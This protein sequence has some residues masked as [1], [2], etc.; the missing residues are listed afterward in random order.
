MPLVTTYAATRDGAQPAGGTSRACSIIEYYI[1]HDAEHA[2]KRRQQTFTPDAGGRN[3]TSPT[4]FLRRRD[5]MRWYY[6]HISASPSP[7]RLHAQQ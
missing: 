5:T 1:S 7:R 3:S 6:I 2:Q 4:G